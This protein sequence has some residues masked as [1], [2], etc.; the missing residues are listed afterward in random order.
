MI[1][2][3][4]DVV[5]GIAGASRNAALA[6]C[7][8]GRVVGVCEQERVTRTRRA[9]VPHGRL[10]RE[11]LETVLS[12][13]GCTEDQISTLATAEPGIQLPC[14]RPV[15]YLDHHF[16][17][18]ATAFYTSPFSDAMVLVCDRHGVPE[19]TV[20][21]ADADGIHQ[22]EFS[23]HGAGFATLYAA[24][25]EAFGFRRD[26]EEHRLEALARI[27]EPQNSTSLPAIAYHGDHVEVPG[28][29][30]ESIAI[31]AGR[32]PN[33]A[34]PERASLAAVVQR[35]LGALLVQVVADVQKRFG[36]THLCLGGGLFYNS[37]FTTVIADSA[38][39]EQ[40]FVP[41]NPGNAGI[42]VGAACAIA[43][44]HGRLVRAGALS[45][46]LGPEF[47]RD[48]IKATLDNCKLS[49]DYLRNGQLIERTVG[50][51]ASGKLVGWF[52]GRMEW[53]SRALGNRSILASPVAPFVLENLN[54]FLKQRE[55]HRTYGVAI[56]AEDLPRF[57]RGPSSSPL[58]EYEYEILDRRLL[59]PLLPLNATRLRVQTVDASA[60]VFYQLLRAFGDATGVPML[61]NTSYN[62]FNEP[63]VC[64]PRDAIRV[65]YGTGLDMAVLDGLVLVK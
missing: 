35:Q 27:G 51:L 53:G 55:P 61:V 21:R 16:G 36:G 30:Q 62:G 33:G 10:P 7:V 56:C 17:H 25:A 13:A 5:L 50:A 26:G 58:M 39:Y 65:F 31:A 41:P 28:G 43:A 22:T 37:Y 18:A 19:L 48:A 57:F 45:P 12:L 44:R 9:P 59:A 1:T 46:F 63:I 15:E 32:A 49:Y 40:T 42:A 38:P 8:D 2:G 6:V 3:M 54:A 64:S 47:S 24:A 4:T 11:A 34:S 20:W 23:W 14:G 29:L 52:Q 60:G